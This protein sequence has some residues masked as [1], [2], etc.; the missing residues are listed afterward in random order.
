MF[1]GNLTNIL[2]IVRS[3]TTAQIVTA[4]AQKV[5]NTN[6]SARV[7]E[8]KSLGAYVIQG[9]QPDVLIAEIDPDD[10]QD[11]AALSRLARAHRGMWVAATAPTGSVATMRRLL[12]EGID[13]FLPQ[14]LDEHDLI[15]TLRAAAASRRE[16]AG[17]P[18]RQGKVLA[19]MRA[20]GGVGATTLAVHTAVGLAAAEKANGRSVCLIDLD[21]QFGNAALSLDLE[22]TSG[23]VDIVRAP[24]RLDGTLLKSAMLQHKSGLHVLS[25]P[26]IPMP[27]DAL[28]PDTAGRIL[29]L[30]CEEFDFVVLDMP[31][32]LAGWTEAVLAAV[33]YLAIVVQLNVPML[34][35]ARR[36]LDVLQEEGHYALPIGIV[37]NRYVRRWG[38]GVDIRNAEKALGRRID[39]LV[40]NDY[41]LVMNAL[42]QG[43]PVF[44]VKR[45]SKF[46]KQVQA[47]A[48]AAVRE[49]A[50][51][52]LAANAG[53]APAG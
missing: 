18:G 31:R 16:A 30:A 19:F 25:A 33:D 48:R 53:T 8:I 28:S 26:A 39:Y 23:L 1:D 52:R 50:T 47:F 11:F 2:A 10:P 45:R 21:V 4:A 49:I 41:R 13:D 20:S 36:L 35:Q 44:D 42:N 12:R 34:R 40:P 32:A 3:A 14:P 46:G 37:C 17:P 24:E 51:V 15:D 29:E 27:L 22:A 6:V 38:D 43:V 5:G 9:A 7:G